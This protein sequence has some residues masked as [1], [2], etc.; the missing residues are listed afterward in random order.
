MI[1][2]LMVDAAQAQLEEMN[3]I[4]EAAEQPYNF[5]GAMTAA[6]GLE[7]VKQHGMDVIILDTGLPDQSGLEL[8]QHIRAIPGYEFVWIIFLSIHQQHETEAYKKAH[9]YDYVIKPYDAGQLFGTIQLLSRYRTI[10]VSDQDRE[11]VTFRQRDQYIRILTKDILYIE[12]I[13]NNS[14]L[15]TY[16]QIFCLRKMSLKK[17]KLM[18][19]DYF[20]QC[21]KSFIVN[22]NYIEAIQKG[23]YGWQIML[24]DYSRS[25]PSGDKYKDEVI[26]LA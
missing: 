13:G 5:Y 12:V 16:S 17:L 3:N 19:P 25:I 4:I 2:I 14:T 18:L 22:R 15:Y 11:F 6:Q 1:N 26:K 8:A 24:K 20:V 7:L 21:H 10:A 9:C 23:P